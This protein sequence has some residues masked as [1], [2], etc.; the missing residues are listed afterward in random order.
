MEPWIA[1]SIA[2]AA[3]QTLRFM[4]QKQLSMGPLSAW[5][6]T[7]ARF[8]YSVPFI[9]A[10]ALGYLLA[11][12]QAWPAVTAEFWV[13]ATIGGLAQILATW[14][15]V[16]LFA[17]RNFAVGITFKKTEVVQTALVGFVILG[18][19]ITWPAMGAVLLGLVGVL[20]LSQM[21]DIGGRWWARLCNRAAALGLISGA[22]FAVSAVGY[23]AAT[24]EIA[25]TDPLLRAGLS[26]AI[27]TV[28]QAAALSL[29][30]AWREPGQVGRVMAAHRT[31]V[32]IG[33]TGMAGSLCWF[34]AFTLQN[35]AMVF[36][37]GQVEVIFSLLAAVLFFGER[38]S[39]REG[40]AI[41]L[42]TLSVV[43]VVLLR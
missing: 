1:L 25:S 4:L 8:V 42:I 12:G 18:D 6:A 37:V 7:L 9:V 36:A 28:L 40:V 31:A 24:L 10:L 22:C 32:W 35:A 30:L 5:G 26:L 38:I 41:T 20:I 2:A 16:A 39:A 29:W 15:V 11:S 13:Y 33:V 3:F 43:G 34:T 21:P 14:C 17:E 27:V 23:R 19:R